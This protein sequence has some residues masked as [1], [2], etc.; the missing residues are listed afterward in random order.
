MSHERTVDGNSHVGD[1]MDVEVEEDGL[2]KP[3]SGLR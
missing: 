2:M 1:H 3:G